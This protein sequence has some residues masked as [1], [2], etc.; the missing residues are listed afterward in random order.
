MDKLFLYLIG[1]SPRQTHHLLLRLKSVSMQSH[2]ILFSIQMDVVGMDCLKSWNVKKI[3]LSKFWNGITLG[4]V[5]SHSEISANEF[6]DG[7]ARTSVKDHLHDQRC[8]HQDKVGKAASIT[9]PRLR[10]LTGILIGHCR[11][12]KHMHC[13]GLTSS[14]QCR[15]CGGAQEIHS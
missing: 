14:P 1:K 9:R 5:P 10:V 12:N 8:P 13:M 2:N 15:S 4:W 11:L 3:V 7:L 6:P